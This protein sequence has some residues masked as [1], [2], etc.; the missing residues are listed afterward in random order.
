M[1]TFSSR[2]PTSDGRIKPDVVG[3]GTNVVSAASD[4]RSG[5]RQCYDQTK[6]PINTP[7]FTPALEVESGTS[8]ATPT[9]AGAAALVRQYY[10]EG[11]HVSGVRNVGNGIVS[12]KSA[13]VKATLIASTVPSQGNIRDLRLCNGSVCTD[14]L[15]ATSENK[16]KFVHGFG[17]VQLANAL[18][19]S[20]DPHMLYQ[21]TNAVS[22]GTTRCYRVNTGSLTTRTTLK[23]VLVW[24]DPAASSSASRLLVNNLNLRTYRVESGAVLLGNEAQTG[25]QCTDTINNVEVTSQELAENAEVVVV[26][27]GTSIN[28]NSQQSYSLVLVGPSTMTVTPLSSCS[29]EYGAYA[30]KDSCSSSSNNDDDDNDEDDQTTAII[31]G[32]VVGV[33]ALIILIIVGGY[34]GWT[35][36]A[37]ARAM[38]HQRQQDV[39]ELVEL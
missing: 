34:W 3:P 11:W 10:R 38:G 26:V 12:P 37:H 7:G 4:I 24:T 29:S 39:E 20:G 8:M 13:L 14:N 15:P 9:I 5:T 18:Y 23:A 6:T 21:D 2:G 31:V 36:W 28:V 35:K 27:E 19:F 1:A 22:S 30:E 17:H 33:V 32:V 16:F 25:S